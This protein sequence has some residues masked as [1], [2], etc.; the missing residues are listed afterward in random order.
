MPL[1]A[2]TSVGS[3]VSGSGG[4]Q[5]TR[6]LAE[7]H[8][9]YLALALAFCRLCSIDPSL[10][11]SL[12][13]FFLFL[14]DGPSDRRPRRKIVRKAD[15][16]E[17][18]RCK[19]EEGRSGGGNRSGRTTLAHPSPLRLGFLLASCVRHD[20]RVQLPRSGSTQHPPSTHPAPESQ[21]KL[22]GGDKAVARTH[23]HGTNEQ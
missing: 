11:L 7:R 8:A 3:E 21:H 10:A 1:Q 12:F 18:S 19:R 17:G 20:T 5:E 22:L 2:V 9:P 4:P 6:C 16:L 15:I 13:L 14:L 23:A